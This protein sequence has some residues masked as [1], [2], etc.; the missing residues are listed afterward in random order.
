MVPSLSTLWQEINK[1]YLHHMEPQ[2]IKLSVALAVYN[3]ENNLGECLETI[4]SI[5]DEIVIVDGQSTDK[6]VEIALQYGAKVI[7]QEN[8][9]NFHINKQHAFLHSQG[10]YNSRYPKYE[11]QV[12][13]VASDYVT[14]HDFVSALHA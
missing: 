1:L 6:T 3:E 14:E 7:S 9:S 13:Y 12:E 5:A 4:K 10:L 8:R 2:V 11:K